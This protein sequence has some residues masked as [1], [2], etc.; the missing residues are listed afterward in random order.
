MLKIKSIKFVN[1]PVFKNKMFDFTTKSNDVASTVIIVGE[2]GSG[3]TRLINILKQLTDF[4]FVNDKK[5]FLYNDKNTRFTKQEIEHNNDFYLNAWE[6]EIEY[7]YT[8]T[9]NEEKLSESEYWIPSSN[10]NLK[11]EFNEINSKLGNKVNFRLDI[12]TSFKNKNIQNNN[13]NIIINNVYLLYEQIN[14]EEYTQLNEKISAKLMYP[15]ISN[16]MVSRTSYDNTNFIFGLLVKGFGYTYYFDTLQEL[17]KSNEKNN[18]S[19]E[20][21]LL[22]VY[23]E[24]FNIENIEYNFSKLDINLFK[25][26]NYARAINQFLKN[27]PNKPNKNENYLELDKITKN[28]IHFKKDNNNIYGRLSNSLEMS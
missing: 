3:K 12:S 18:Q 19:Y 27:F 10:L 22:N 20:E 14:K 13:Y 21:F 23:K 1:D 16:V 17:S 15:V 11:N 28:N 2:N 9:P 8:F 26:N 5:D 24:E 7:E 4:I 6:Y 25:L